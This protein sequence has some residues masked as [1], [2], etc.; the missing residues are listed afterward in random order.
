MRVNFFFFNLILLV[1]LNDN[2]FTQFA[3]FAKTPV[4]YAI[5]TIQS[6]L[7]LSKLYIW[8]VLQTRK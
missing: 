6:S 4:T 7:P 8:T 1:V 2:L 5:C 3:P